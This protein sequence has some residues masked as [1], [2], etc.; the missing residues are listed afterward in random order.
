MNNTINC[1][2]KKGDT[3]TWAE[4][5]AENDSRSFYR[6][7]THSHFQCTTVTST[8]TCVPHLC[9]VTPMRYH[10]YKNNTEATTTLYWQSVK[11]KIKHPI[12]KKKKEFVQ[13]LATGM[14]IM[15]SQAYGKKSYRIV[16]LFIFSGICHR[17]QIESTKVIPPCFSHLSPFSGCPHRWGKSTSILIPGE[18]FNFVHLPCLNC[19]TIT[20]QQ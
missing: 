20:N 1:L 16:S 13:Q 11:D 19:R 17:E 5:V 15:T 18:Y 10:A 4:H 6:T 9:Q 14:L 8:P 7:P 3:N 2:F 12:R